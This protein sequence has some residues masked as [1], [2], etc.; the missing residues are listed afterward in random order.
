MPLKLEG[1]KGAPPGEVP[2]VNM[3]LSGVRGKER[4]PL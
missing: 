3:W 1:H 2:N 4:R